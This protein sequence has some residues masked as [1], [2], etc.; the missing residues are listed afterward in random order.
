MRNRL[1]IKRHPQYVK[2]LQ[3]AE[4]ATK[5]EE[6]LIVPNLE[7]GGVPYV[8]QGHLIS[9][10]ETDLK[11]SILYSSRDSMEVRKYLDTLQKLNLIEFKFT[12]LSSFLE[13]HNF[14]NVEKISQTGEYSVIG[15]QVRFWPVGYE[16]PIRVIY[17]GDSYEKAET[18]DE[19]YNK[20]QSIVK[21]VLIGDLEEL[22]SQA[23]LDQIQLGSS[24]K[25]PLKLSVIFGGD[26]LDT[27]DSSQAVT[28]DFTYPQ[29]YF[30]RFDL[31]ERDINRFQDKGYE[32]HL[33]TKH[34]SSVPPKLKGLVSKH[35]ADIEAGF[36]S[37]S[38]KYTVFTDRELFGTVFL[39]RQTKGLSS[40]H[41][42]KLLAQLEG[43]IE[44]GNA[45]VH[46][47]YGIGIYKGI[48]Q[49]EFEQ[50]IPLGFNE[51]KRIKVYEDYLL[52]A[53]AEGDELLVP[54]SQIDKVTK[55]IGPDDDDPKITRLGR[56]DWGRIK[57]K[58]KASVA[59]LAKEL[60]EHY[61]KR[62]LAKASAIDPE[63]SKTYENFLLDFPY[64]ETDDQLRTEKEVIND[65]A[66]DRPMNRLIVGDVGFGK[67][68]IAMRAAFKAVEQ[69]Y[70]VAFL[71]PT[72]VLVAQHFK[73][74]T[75]RFSDTPYIIGSLSRFSS[76]NNKRTIA[77]L[78]ENKIDIVVGTHRLLSNDIEFRKLGLLIVDEEQ[79]F[80]VKQKEKLKKL[81]YGVHVLSLSATPIP[82]TLSMAL[83]TIQ[84]ISI[85]QTPP[86]GRKSVET[87][88]AKHNPQKVVD[89][90]LSELKRGGQVYYVHNRVRT[91]NSVY[92]KLQ[93]LLPKV[94]FVVGH[95]QMTPE[96]LEE[97]ISSF[98]SKMY[99]VLICTTI[100]ENGIDMPNVN[101][102]I[103]EQSQNFGLGQLYQLR[104]RVGRGQIQAYA[105]MFYE[106]EDPDQKYFDEQLESID[107]KLAK[108]KKKHQKYKERL[109]A[110]MELQEL[111]SG[112][113]LA[114]RDLEI[115][116]AGN[117]LGRE[118]H[119]NIANIGYG[120][121]MQLLAQE[122]ER[123]KQLTEL[124]NQNK[125]K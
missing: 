69:G 116:G 37:K 122:I 47:D 23:V 66:G 13:N 39:S 100:I 102:I 93:R 86:E 91:I 105:Y 115:R 97:N 22:N 32:V 121:Y 33:L 73:V 48:K 90:I 5:E 54:L 123:L 75:E 80:G 24:D 113:S 6:G 41:A 12:D 34:K 57:R 30:G 72:T 74:L 83:A 52:V 27:Y 38:L 70:Q 20:T 79:K 82:R 55:Y 89:A 94:R 108:K 71:S 45:V 28:F 103:I 109:R 59:V 60:V 58:V 4:K 29:L 92:A 104:G 35:F 31:L 7:I 120:M 67:T 26:N 124:K 50:K 1:P 78:K 95:G 76:R 56:A 49:E 85:I 21:S 43:E 77:E 99:D 64:Q 118:Q 46:E 101:T 18:Y 110:L 36:I 106:G 63:S 81:Q 68:E 65:M 40:K 25:S 53:Y 117:L 3:V 19:I 42:R 17:F 125:V 8:L 14:E 88:V 10:L 87:V 111:G 98:Y 61:A 11:S 84:D 51:F 112:F 15:D 44:I 16:H 96:Q 114:S 2:L 119:G 62:L 9:E 107:P